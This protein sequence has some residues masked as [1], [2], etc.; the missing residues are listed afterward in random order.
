MWYW[1]C[2]ESLGNRL[3]GMRGE[4]EQELGTSLGSKE[5]TFSLD[6]V[7]RGEGR[8]RSWGHL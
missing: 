3:K 5:C 1:M 8:D 7:G 2:R 4:N 6:K